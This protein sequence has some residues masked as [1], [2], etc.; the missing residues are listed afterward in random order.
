MS[1]HYELWP[2]NCPD[3]GQIIGDAGRILRERISSGT[4]AYEAARDMGYTSTCCLL[5]LQTPTTYELR[6]AHR[7]KISESVLNP[8]QPM[9]V[10]SVDSGRTKM[11]G[12]NISSQSSVFTTESPEEDAS[13]RASIRGIT[14][15]KVRPN[16]DISRIEKGG[17][18][19][20][21]FQ[22]DSSGKEVMI[23]VGA[24]YYVPVLTYIVKTSKNN[25]VGYYNED[26]EGS[27]F[28]KRK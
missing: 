14:E 7:G 20:T 4:P 1:N 2:S 26:I 13:K 18:M 22:R 15:P 27:D 12:A 5:A 28:R 11:V 8:Q 21:G 10:I 23:N 9:Q 25:P 16:I 3:C 17:V 19:V 6:P 24:G